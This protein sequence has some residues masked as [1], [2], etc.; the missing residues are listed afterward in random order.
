MQNIIVIA[1]PSSE[2]T[3]LVNWSILNTVPFP[4]W[5]RKGN[6]RKQS[7][8]EIWESKENF[9]FNRRFS[10]D[11]LSGLCKG[12]KWGS[13]CRGGCTEKAISCTGSPYESPYCLYKYEKAHGIC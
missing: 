2:F 4:R 10:P 6:I 1:I 5:R 9:K 12:C 7:L 13:I 11:K 3:A 8:K